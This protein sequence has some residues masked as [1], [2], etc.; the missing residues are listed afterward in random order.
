MFQPSKDLS[1]SGKDHMTSY[2][3]SGS[4]SPTAAPLHAGS[5]FSSRWNMDMPATFRPYERT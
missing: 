1:S 5:Y 4:G 3:L 2:L